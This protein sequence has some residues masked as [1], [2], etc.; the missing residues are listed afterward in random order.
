MGRLNDVDGNKSINASTLNTLDFDYTT[1]LLYVIAHEPARL[2]VF[3]L[4]ID[5][6]PT[7]VME[8]K[9]ST[10][11]EGY[12]LDLEVCRPEAFGATPRVA[13][14]FQD[15]ASRSADGRVIFYQPLSFTR[16]ELREIQ[17]INV[18]AYPTDLEFAD[19]C[20][21]L[22]VANKGQPTREGNNQFR[23][24]EGTLT[25]VSMP[26]DFSDMSPVRSTTISF[27]DY[28]Q[29]LNGQE[30]RNDCL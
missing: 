7:Q 24:P 5:G 15:P 21:V 27:G 14:S 13:I 2:T 4:G 17:R 23:D 11:L 12:P 3:S 8:H 28:F 18:G 1:N 10:V 29:S 22:I 26:Q 6:T 9:F 19:D 25:K 20:G 16:A 30:R